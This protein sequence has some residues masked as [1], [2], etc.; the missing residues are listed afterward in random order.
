[1]QEVIISGEFQLREDLDKE[2]RE[3]VLEEIKE[4]FNVYSFEEEEQCHYF[5]FICMKSQIDP[6]EIKRVF[7][8]L[9]KD[10]LIATI[11]IWNIREPDFKFHLDESEILY[12]MK[13]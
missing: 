1:M 12:K 8:N 5:K 10:V 4:V 13:I 2:K 7:M 9:R 6:E 11:E 3:E